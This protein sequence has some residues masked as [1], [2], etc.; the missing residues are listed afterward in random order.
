MFPRQHRH[1]VHSVHAEDEPLDAMEQPFAGLLA[2][3]HR[4][5]RVA[6]MT[7]LAVAGAI[8]AFMVAHGLRASVVGGSHPPAVA[9]SG[10][11]ARSVE[12]R[13]RMGQRHRVG[14]RHR[15]ARPVAQARGAGIV[16]AAHEAVSSPAAAARAVAGTGAAGSEF[17]FER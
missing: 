3:P 13:H 7:L 9:G 12:Q 8:V 15:Q 16:P 4:S 14:Q 2:D 17:N 11:P 1:A 6:A 10:V 5:R